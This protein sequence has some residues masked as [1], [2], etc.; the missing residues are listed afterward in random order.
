MPSKWGS[1]YPGLA[2]C[3][4]YHQIYSC[5]RLKL[6]AFEKQPVP[7]IGEV[8]RNLPLWLPMVSLRPQ[9]VGH[10]DV[11]AGCA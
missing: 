7:P 3:I 8:Q 10:T 11:A 1:L 5:E 4:N 9:V 6:L 2:D